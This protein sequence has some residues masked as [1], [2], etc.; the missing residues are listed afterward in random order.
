MDKEI[1]ILFTDENTE[2]MMYGHTDVIYSNTKD[3]KG[4]LAEINYEKYFKAMEFLLENAKSYDYIHIGLVEVESR[5]GIVWD[6]KGTVSSRIV[7]TFTSTPG[8]SL[9]ISFSAPSSTSFAFSHE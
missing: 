3:V 1:C 5:H 6:I 8:E 7:L 9:K 2:K 4:F